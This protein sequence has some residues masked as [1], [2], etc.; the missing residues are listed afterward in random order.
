MNPG[1]SP[2]GPST[3]PPPSGRAR[4]RHFMVSWLVVLLMLATLM[5]TGGFG[6]LL[7]GHV[8]RIALSPELAF[9][10]LW[11]PLVA[12]PLGLSVLAG[13]LWLLGYG[14]KILGG[15]LVASR[16]LALRRQAEAGAGA[17]PK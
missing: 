11:H 2:F 3:G 1:V 4:A 12:V 5:V 6:A 16:E 7:L 17:K 14:L 9:R 13:S 15:V 10:S 8:A